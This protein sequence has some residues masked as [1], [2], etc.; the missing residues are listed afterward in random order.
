MP[1]LLKSTINILLA[2]DDKDDTELFKEVLEELPI[3]IQL[4]TVYN[5]EQL[6]QLLNQEKK[7]LPDVLFLD[8]NMP[9]KSGFECFS[10]IK[11]DEKLKQLPV[12]IFT[13][14]FEPEVVNLLF[15]KGAHYYIRK[16]NDYSHLKKVI[17]QAIMLT[18][19]TNL[20]KPPRD[21]FVLSQESFYNEHK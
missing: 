15:S 6:M 16:P 10:E 4:E 7:Q 1:S 11:Q 2:D 17:H 18:S 14:S 8:L 13:T 20:I 3:S 21:K 5:G 19:Q 12:I 9:R